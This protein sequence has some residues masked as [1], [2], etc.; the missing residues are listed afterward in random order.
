MK[1]MVETIFK[2]SNLNFVQAFGRTGGEHH[3]VLPQNRRFAGSNRWIQL[4]VHRFLAPHYSST[5]HGSIPAL[6]TGNGSILVAVLH[7][8]R[9]TGALSPCRRVAPV[10]ETIP[11]AYLALAPLPASPSNA[12]RPWPRE[13]AAP[14]PH[15]RAA[16]PE[17]A[18]SPPGRPPCQ[19]RATPP[20]SPF[21][22]LGH[23]TP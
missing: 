6:W 13:P 7:R 5:P 8:R 10:E 2:N 18:P 22:P 16:P 4:F 17:H 11:P 1:P 20:R 14:T 15:G 21:L 23:P 19:A 3:P 12:P 9:G